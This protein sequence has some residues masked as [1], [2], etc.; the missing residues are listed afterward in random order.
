MADVSALFKSADGS[1]DSGIKA[2]VY[3]NGEYAGEAD[4]LSR[5]EPGA[6]E[7]IL[8][9]FTFDL[10]ANAVGAQE[11]EFIIVNGDETASALFG[12]C[13]Q[14]ARSPII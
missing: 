9:S 5:A 3:V 11:I 13:Q 7:E 12:K 4:K 2:Y 8:G 10:N 6:G 14:K 1:Y